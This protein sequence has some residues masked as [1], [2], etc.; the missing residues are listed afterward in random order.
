MIRGL[1]P[2]RRPDR[3][4]AECRWP[5][6]AAVAVLAALAA[7][8]AQARDNLGMA[9]KW[10]AFRDPAVPRCYAIAKAE[11][12]LFEREFQPFAAIGTW[13]RRGERGQVHFRLSRRLAQDA[14]VTLTLGGQRFVLTGSGA[15]AWS[16]NRQMDAAI[17]AAMR[18]AK[19][20]AVS[21]RDARRRPFGNSYDL[22]GAAT[23][24]DTAT[25]ACAR[26]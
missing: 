18:S 1:I 19:T 25:L 6:F 4:G 5:M 12:S 17:V 14:R 23:A 13:P 16:A 20:M 21:A 26:L 2:D 24:M 11:P 9:G 7:A 22:A 3:V 10:G 8:P 15:D